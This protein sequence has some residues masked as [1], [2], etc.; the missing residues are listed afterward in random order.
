[1]KK[2]LVVFVAS[3]FLCMSCGDDDDASSGGSS[4]SSPVISSLECDPVSAAVAEGSGAINMDCSIF[5]RDQD[6]DLDRVVLRYP[7]GCRTVSQVSIDVSAQTGVQQQGTIQIQD[8]IIQTSCVA[9]TYSYRFEAV[10]RKG[11][12]SNT[13]TLEF[14]LF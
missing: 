13:L 4:G 3:V 8:L 9:G 12:T 14:E 11:K 6:G 2:L 7:Q 5:F 1:M 10:D